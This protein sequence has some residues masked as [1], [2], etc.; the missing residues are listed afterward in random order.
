MNFDT[1]EPVYERILAD[2]GYDRAG[3]ERARDVLGVIL[4]ST[5]TYEPRALGIE[6]QTVAVVGAGPSVE[7][8]ADR[9]ADADIVVAASTAADRLRAV[10]VRVDCMVTDLDKN[11]E[12][13]AELT[14]SGT[15]VLVHAHGDNVPAVEAFVPTYDPAFVV[16]TTQAAPTDAVHDFGGFTDGD[17]AAFFADHFGADGLVFVGWDFDDP[18]VDPEKRQKLRW[19]ERLLYWLERRRGERFAILDGRRDGIDP[20]DGP[21]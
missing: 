11:A 7:D 14:R 3:D 21:D 15:P 12:T 10:G 2:F 5:A 17:R 18:S 6:G 8:E 9:A 1:W 4:E 20:I 13:G 19:A 16:P